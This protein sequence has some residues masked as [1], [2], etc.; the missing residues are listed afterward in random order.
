M[1]HLARRLALPRSSA[2]VVLA[3]AA[4]LTMAAPAYALDRRSEERVTV[5]AGE[6]VKDDLA[7]SGTYVT[8]DGQVKG[9]VFAW[10]QSV[11]VGG[12]IEGDLIAAAQQVVVNG[13]VRGNVRAAGAQVT[14]NGSVG[15]SVTNFGQALQLGSGGRVMG[16]WI[17]AGERVS[18]FGDVDGPL[19]AAAESVGLQGRVTGNAEVASGGLSFGPNAFVGG[20]LTYYADHDLTVPTS[21]VAGKVE[22]RQMSTKDGHNLSFRDHQRSAKRFAAPSQIF[23]AVY[24]FV[25]LA[26]LAGSGV[27][28][29]LVLRLFPRLVAG[30]LGA[31][32]ARPV[33]SFLL[34][35]CAMICTVPAAFLLGV[36]LIGLPIS[37]LLMTGFIGGLLLGWP[38][39]AVAVG[40]IL[41][42][43]VRGGRPWRH[44]WAFLLGLLVLYLSTRIPFA[45]PLLLFVELSFG[46]GAALLAFYYTWR[47]RGIPRSE[48]PLLGT[49]TAA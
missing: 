15:R 49:V 16:S 43:M 22:R 10:A 19:A 24:N 3:L 35:L 29:L 39:L 8:I 31:L 42:G 32:E 38:L 9:D 23:G 12:V 28:G 34:G 46:L 13:T 47:G 26:F 7:I 41:V 40:S 11:T 14:I 18:I 30:F 27:L 17:G 37:A 33:P 36:T 5:A 44:S 4:I 1:I 6:V 2:A 48:H 25:S 21:A 45:G 20:N